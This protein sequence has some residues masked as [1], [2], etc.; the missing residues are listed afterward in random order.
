MGFLKRF[1][2][3]SGPFMGSPKNLDTSRTNLLTKATYQIVPG[4]HGAHMAQLDLQFLRTSLSGAANPDMTL[5][6]VLDRSGSMTET[7]SDGH[8][9]NA[10]SA[11]LAHV[12]QVGIGFDLVFYDS[13]RPL[14][15]ISR[16]LANCRA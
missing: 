6:L 4:P 1:G 2:G 16:R 8:V 14:P 10:A 11:I 12:A 5:A 13:S 9:Y 15:V 7:Y 3:G